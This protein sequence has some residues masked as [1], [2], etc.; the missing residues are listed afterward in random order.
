M[1][2]LAVVLVPLAGEVIATHPPPQPPKFTVIVAAAVPNEF[3][4][5]TV[6]VFAPTTS[7]TEFVLGVVDAAPLTVQVV[8]DGIVVPPLTV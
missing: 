4:H 5:A 1:I 8:P 6:M 2:E 3:V 7:A